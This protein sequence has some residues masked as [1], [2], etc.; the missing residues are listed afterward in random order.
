M[1]SRSCGRLQTPI[2]GKSEV[3]R[4]LVKDALKRSKARG[5]R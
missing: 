1:R 3:I 5:K 4:E 2:P